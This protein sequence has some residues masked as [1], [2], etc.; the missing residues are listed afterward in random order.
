MY[1]SNQARS[2]QYL[3]GFPQGAGRP[4]PQ[5]PP[6]FA[7]AAPIARTAPRRRPPRTSP[8]PSPSFSY[9]L[10][11]RSGRALAPTNQVPITIPISRI[12]L[13]AICLSFSSPPNSPLPFYSPSLSLSFLSICLFL[14]VCFLFARMVGIVIYLLL[15]RE[16]KIYG[17]SFACYSF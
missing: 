8:H 11:P 16:P 2:N 17:S 14:P 10:R 6:A 3:L 13:F 9:N 7:A 15:N 1:Q 5:P 12:T 4:K